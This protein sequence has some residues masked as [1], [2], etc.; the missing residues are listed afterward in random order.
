MRQAAAKPL[1]LESV[2]CGGLEIAWHNGGPRWDAILAISTSTPLQNTQRSGSL[3]RAAGCDKV[4]ERG[5]SELLRTPCVLQDLAIRS[6]AR[7]QDL[8]EDVQKPASHQFERIE[9]FAF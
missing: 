7:E 6:A 9:R 1:L 8:G 2:S 4:R 3:F 5:G